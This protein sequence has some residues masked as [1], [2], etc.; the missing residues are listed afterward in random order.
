MLYWFLDLDFW[1]NH[2]IFAHL[3]L[4]FD[5]CL[6]AALLERPNWVEIETSKAHN[7]WF[8]C[9]VWLLVVYL[10]DKFLFFYMQKRTNCLFLFLSTRFY[11][12]I[13]EY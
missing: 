3:L 10:F 5:K 9:K 2:E 7:C 12:Y 6:A 13:F 11:F 8:L 1:N 4:N